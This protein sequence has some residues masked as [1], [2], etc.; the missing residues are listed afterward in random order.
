ME[1]SIIANKEIEITSVYF[2][3]N[4]QKQRFESY[5]KRMVYDGRE[6]T[7]MES[8]MRYLVRKGQE[9][10]KLFDVSDGDTLY[11]LRLDSQNR[12]T[13]VNMRVNA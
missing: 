11:R 4:P 2:R 9:L 1:T 13:L 12:W 6:Y 3:N 5:P 10:I 7:F 8:G